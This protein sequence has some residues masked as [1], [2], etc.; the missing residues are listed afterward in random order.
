MPPSPT[1]Y[2]YQWYHGTLA[3]NESNK[4]L[5]EHAAIL[6][7]NTGDPNQ[8]DKETDFSSGVFLIRL[9]EKSGDEVLTLLYED[10]PRH[11][12][13]QKYVSRALVELMVST[14]INLFLAYIV[15]ALISIH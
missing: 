15:V 1:I 7:R 14:K 3:R 12:I 5:K 10:Q 13:I 9:S 8:E 6:A 2:K 4:I 11:F